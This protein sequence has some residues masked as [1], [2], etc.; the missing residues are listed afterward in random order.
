MADTKSNKMIAKSKFNLVHFLVQIT[1]SL[2]PDLLD[3]AI[4][5]E[6]VLKAATRMTSFSSLSL[7]RLLIFANFVTVSWATVTAD[8]RELRAGLTQ[9]EKDIPT[10]PKQ[11]DEDRLAEV[12]E[13]AHVFLFRLL[14]SLI[15]RDLHTACF[16]PQ[17]PPSVPPRFIKIQKSTHAN[18]QIHSRNKPPRK[19]RSCDTHK[20]D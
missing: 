14:F 18:T 6:G 11:G 9:L 13:V 16:L 20:T 17:F 7:S 19:Q 12:M 1:E 5:I 8:L 10:I 4:E 2:R 3:F 15:T